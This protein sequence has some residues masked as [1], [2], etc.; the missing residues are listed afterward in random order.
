MCIKYWSYVFYIQSEGSIYQG[1]LVTLLFWV[2]ASHCLNTTPH[3][4]QQTHIHT[5]LEIKNRNTSWKQKQKQWIMIQII[6]YNCV[7]LNHSS[8][9]LIVDLKNEIAAQNLKHNLH[10]SIICFICLT[11][12]NINA[13]KQM[14]FSTEQN[15]G[16]WEVNKL[17]SINIGRLE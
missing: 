4:P 11:A 1:F 14:N 2:S 17:L 10:A 15:C 5:T 12:V 6:M 13:N 8:N 16:I 7:N 3:S 9:W